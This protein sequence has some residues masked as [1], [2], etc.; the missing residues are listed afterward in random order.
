MYLPHKFGSD[1]RHFCSCPA[2]L[3]ILFGLFKECVLNHRLSS[4][5][6]DFD[7]LIVKDFIAHFEDNHKISFPNDKVM[8]RRLKNQCREVK[9]NIMGIGSD[10]PIDVMSQ[11]NMD[12]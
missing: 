10:L 9:E 11:P 7:E 5:G 2:T 4:G 8:R 3:Y 12:L 1:P 6:E